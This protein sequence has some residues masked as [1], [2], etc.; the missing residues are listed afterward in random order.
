MSIAFSVS[1][2][3]PFLYLTKF[4]AIGQFILPVLIIRYR[5]RFIKLPT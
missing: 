5:E 1:A 3:R 2:T 4:P